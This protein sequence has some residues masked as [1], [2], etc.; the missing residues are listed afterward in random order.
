MKSVITFSYSNFMG[1]FLAP[2]NVITM[3]YQEAL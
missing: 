1:L 2:L 3:Q